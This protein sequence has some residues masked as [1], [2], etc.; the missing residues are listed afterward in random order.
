[1]LDRL[2]KLLPRPALTV[3]IDVPAEVA[4]ARKDD[5]R[6]VD[7]LRERRARY[8]RLRARPEIRPFDGEAPPEALLRALLRETAACPRAATARGAR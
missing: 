2:L 4:F 8:L 5:V 1:M 7:Y 6:H 3:L